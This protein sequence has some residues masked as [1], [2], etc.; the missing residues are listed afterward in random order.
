MEGQPRRSGPI[1]PQDDDSA[2]CCCEFYN[3]RGER[4]HILQ[5]CCACEEIDEEGG[6]LFATAFESNVASLVYSPDYTKI[7]VGT[8]AGETCLVAYKTEQLPV[9]VV[10]AASL[11]DISSKVASFHTDAVVAAAPLA[12]LADDGSVAGYDIVTCSTDGTLR[13]TDALTRMEVGRV[14]PA[15]LAPPSAL[16]SLPR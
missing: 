15:S 5:C 13:C 10:D 6:L 14:T 4:T 12:V 2:L 11:M 1:Y 7:L 3:R 9:A 16:A 8:G